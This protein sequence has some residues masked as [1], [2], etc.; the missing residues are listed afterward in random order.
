MIVS[1]KPLFP[2]RI[3]FASA[4]VAAFIFSLSPLSAAEHNA[5]NEMS[6]TLLAKHRERCGDAVENPFDVGVD[7]VFPI[8]HAQVVQRGDRPNASVVDENVKLTVSLTRQVD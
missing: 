8:L 6:E 2:S 3:A 4:S 1:V 7:Y 5:V